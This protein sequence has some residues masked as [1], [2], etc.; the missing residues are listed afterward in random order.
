MQLHK[1]QQQQQQQQQQLEF[2][3]FLPIQ[4]LLI[5][6]HCINITLLHVNIQ[7]YF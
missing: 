5:I 6:D 7:C 1:Q 3:I 2:K 4:N